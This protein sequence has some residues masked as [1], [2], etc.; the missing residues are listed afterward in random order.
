MIRYFTPSRVSARAEWVRR[1]TLL[2]RSDRQIR[3]VLY[4]VPGP[5][6]SVA[7]VLAMLDRERADAA[8]TGE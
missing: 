5:A 2:V 6:G 3:G 8:R 1:I 7:D 4:P